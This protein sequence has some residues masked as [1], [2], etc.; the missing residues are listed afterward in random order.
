MKK[1]A[2]ALVCA[3]GVGL[4]AYPALKKNV[5]NKSVTEKKMEK[6]EKKKECKRSCWFE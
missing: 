4:I 5:S 2:V 1:F 3:L 6:E